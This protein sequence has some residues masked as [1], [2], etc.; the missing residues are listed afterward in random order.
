[1]TLAPSPASALTDEAREPT[2]RT[3]VLA[4]RNAGK[5]REFRAIFEPLGWRILN[6]GDVS[7]PDV[8]E[9]TAPEGGTFA[10][11]ATLKAESACKATGFWALADDSGLCVEALGGAPGVDSAHY[12]GF[13]RLLEALGGVEKDRR[14]AFFTCVLALARPGME[15]LLFEGRDDGMIAERP[16]GDGGF[17][18]DPV[19]IP[20]GRDMTFAEM[21]TELKMATSHRG[22]AVK[23]FLEW[24]TAHAS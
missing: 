16:A 22:K 17:G 4:T 12:G 19:F 2:P 10:G 21:P 1:M 5:T 14:S 20:E 3:L 23:R 7:L 18:Y 11:N 13:E 6:A 15:T 24:V 9:L 8:V